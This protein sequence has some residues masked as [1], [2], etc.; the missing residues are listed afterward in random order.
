MKTC[1]TCELWKFERRDWE[2]DELRLGECKGIKQ[3]SSIESDALDA[4]GNP[5]RW[6]TKGEAAIKAAML[7]TKAIA[8]DGSGYY[9]A[10]RTA[11][12]FGCI[13]HVEKP[14]PST[15]E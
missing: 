8:V 10:L 11:P 7:A 6:S 14:A 1:E 12:D 5:D 15:P 3:R 2:Y 4:A 13:L 9:A